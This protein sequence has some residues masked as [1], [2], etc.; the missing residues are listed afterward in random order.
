MVYAQIW[1]KDFV[2]ETTRPMV[3]RLQG[4]R[5]SSEPLPF[6]VDTKYVHPEIA[7][8]IVEAYYRLAPQYVQA[9]HAITPDDIERL[10]SMDLFDVGLNPAT[11]LH[12]LKISFDV[13]NLNLPFNVQVDVEHITEALSWL[14]KIVKKKA[15]KLTI[16]LVQ[17]RVRLSLWEGYFMILK[18]FLQ[19][20][21][22]EGATVKIWWRYR[23]HNRPPDRI[24]ICLNDLVRES[25]PEWKR[26]PEWMKD[27]TERL[28]R[29]EDIEDLHREYLQEDRDDY[30]PIDYPSDD[31]Y[32][33]DHRDFCLCR[34]CESERR[35]AD[36]SDCDS[37]E[38]G[39]EDDGETEETDS[40][41]DEEDEWDEDDDGMPW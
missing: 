21:E 10:V 6:V 18:P 28:E 36:N 25:G 32:V 14:M 19:A 1:T 16:E 27:M 40:L 39:D 29:F 13:D 11:V 31:D 37:T 24:V 5:G 8:E 26:N 3:G 33:S 22:K 38:D 4:G 7:L 12:E 20:F 9:F 15:F 17:R 23:D 30:Y 34:S 35:L 41:D 2:L